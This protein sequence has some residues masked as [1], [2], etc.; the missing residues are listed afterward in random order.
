MTAEE[1][2]TLRNSLPAYRTRPSNIELWDRAF[3]EYN[4]YRVNAGM[5]EKS[6][7]CI[8]C[9]PQVLQYHQSKQK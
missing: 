5:P 4:E 2:E 3:K 9:Y 7:K 1:I 6:I 8:V